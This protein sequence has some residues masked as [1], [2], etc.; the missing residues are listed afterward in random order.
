MGARGKGAVKRWRAATRRVATCLEPGRLP[1]R[2]ANSRTVRV[3]NEEAK[4]ESADRDGG[5]AEAASAAED[6]LE[7]KLER[8]PKASGCYL[9]K[10]K[11][12]RRRLRGQGEEPALA[13]EELLPGVGERRALLHPHPAPDRA[14]PRRRSSPPPRRR[15]PSSRTTSS[16]STSRAS[17]SSC[18]TTRTSSACASTRRR[19]WPRLETVRRPSAGRRALL[20]ALPLGDQRAAARSTSSTSTSSSAPAPT[21]SSRRAGGPASSTRSSAARRPA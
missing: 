3:V 6:L 8:L 1:P 20:R 18:A 11:D 21:P 16:S 2:P 15:R 10:D 5:E 17:T 7:A 12:G 4:L 9:F 19:Q 13:R 14:R